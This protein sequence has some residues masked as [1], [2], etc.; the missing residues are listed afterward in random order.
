MG[1][2]MDQTYGKFVV[3]TVSFDY[4]VEN[5]VRKRNKTRTPVKYVPCNDDR[6][7]GFN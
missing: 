1:K 6:F 4:V 2:K 3:N 7:L 5:G